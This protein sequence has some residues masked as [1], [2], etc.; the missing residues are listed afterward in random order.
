MPRRRSPRSP[1][2]HSSWRARVPTHWGRTTWDMLFKLA[3][4][5]PHARECADDDAYPRAV[6]RE[7]RRAWRQLLTSLPGT[8]TCGVCSH[9]FAKFLARDGGRP[10]ERALRDR[11]SLFAWLHEAKDEVNKRN[12]RRSPSL[13]RTRRRYIPPCPTP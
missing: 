4:D 9:H 3:A 7:R 5:Y 2:L 12:G 11:E 13:R 10:L 1:P 6:V 8:M